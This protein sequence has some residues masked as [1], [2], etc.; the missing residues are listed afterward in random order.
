MNT[1]QRACSSLTAACLASASKS[2]L[3]R[4]TLRVLNIRLKSSQCLIKSS[5]CATVNTTTIKL[6]YLARYGI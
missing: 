4:K 3:R 5:N 1:L 6:Y 2:V